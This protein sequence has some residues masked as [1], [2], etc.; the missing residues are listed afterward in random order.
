MTEVT[1]RIREVLK[2]NSRLKN[3]HNSMMDP[4]TKVCFV[5]VANDPNS[6]NYYNHFHFKYQKPSSKLKF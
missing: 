3:H 5:S 4:V 2:V 6:L 1:G